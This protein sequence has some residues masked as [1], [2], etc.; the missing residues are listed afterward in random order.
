MPKAPKTIL[1][2]IGKAPINPCSVV[3]LSGPIVVKM[4]EN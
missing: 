1:T 2:G 4:L 3:P